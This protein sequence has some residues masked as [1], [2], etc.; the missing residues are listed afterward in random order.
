[1]GAAVGRVKNAPSAKLGP[2]SKKGA[3]RRVLTE[4]SVEN[5]GEAARHNIGLGSGGGK[6]F[7]HSLLETGREGNGGRKEERKG[8]PSLPPF[9]FSAVNNN[10]KGRGHPPA[11]ERREEVGRVACITLQSGKGPKGGVSPFIYSNSTPPPYSFKSQYGRGGS[12]RGGTPQAS[13]C[14]QGEG[15]ICAL[16]LCPLSCLFVQAPS[17]EARKEKGREKRCHVWH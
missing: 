17:Q 15:R 10:G 16:L 8:P 14:M 12:K 5:F 3:T 13:A 6:K 2:K 7:F 4:N 9:S 11:G 1:M